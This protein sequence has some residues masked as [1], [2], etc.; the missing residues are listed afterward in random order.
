MRLNENDHEILRS[1]F[2]VYKYHKLQAY[3]SNIII[4]LCIFSFSILSVC[5]LYASTS[6]SFQAASGHLEGDAEPGGHCRGSSRPG[7]VRQVLP[8]GKEVSAHTTTHVIV[9]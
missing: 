1:V 4:Y 7:R 6:V 2:H 3:A 9:H 8:Q 5:V